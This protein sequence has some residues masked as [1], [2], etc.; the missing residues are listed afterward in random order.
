MERFLL[1]VVVL[2]CRIT[3]EV[4]LF[5]WANCSGSW[6]VAQVL[7]P[8]DLAMQDYFGHS[9][10]Q[11]RSVQ[12]FTGCRCIHPSLLAIAQVQTRPYWCLGR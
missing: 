4:C 8:S 5:V 2:T 11:Y 7:K 12:T 9:V 10:A 1:E 3:Y 6:R